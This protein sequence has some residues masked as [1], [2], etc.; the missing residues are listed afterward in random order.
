MHGVAEAQAGLRETEAAGRAAQ[1][2]SELVRG[3]APGPHLLLARIAW[4][5]K[6][7]PQARLHLNRYLALNTSARALPEIQKSLHLLKAC[8]P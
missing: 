6:D 1:A 4:D 5:R 2:A 3:K 7:C 8:S